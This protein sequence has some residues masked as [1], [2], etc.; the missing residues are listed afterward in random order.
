[1]MRAT[2]PAWATVTIAFFL[3]ILGMTTEAVGEPIDPDKWKPS[4]EDERSYAAVSERFADE[5]EAYD[6]AR[7]FRQLEY[8]LRKWMESGPSDTV[9]QHL[10]DAFEI[11]NARFVDYDKLLKEL[12]LERGKSPDEAVEAF[13]E[14]H[15]TGYFNPVGWKWFKPPNTVSYED[16]G[17]MDDTA[18]AEDFLYRVTTVQSLLARFS[19]DIRNE[20][21]RGIHLAARRWEHYLDDGK[22]MYPWEVIVNGMLIRGY[23]IETPPMHQWILLHPQVCASLSSDSWSELKAKDAMCV[24]ALG[25]MWYS[26]KDDDHPENGMR[27]LGASAIAVLRD[28]A[29]PGLGAALEFGRAATI[30]AAWYDSDGDNDWFDDE[31][32]VILSID[33]LSFA[34]EEMNAYRSTAN[35]AIERLGA[36]IDR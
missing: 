14:V 8:D 2:P 11:L 3:L 34:R 31:P 24:Q 25:H 33:L 16:V 21:F 6:Y 20:N 1:M 5:V 4:A 26:W 36:L 7:I 17:K 13:M 10:L 28:D 15:P 12:V 22:M 23:D 29:G 9:H 35:E 18:S 19:E 27:W 30:G 32:S